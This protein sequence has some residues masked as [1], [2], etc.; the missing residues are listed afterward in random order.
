M[1]G[2][3]AWTKFT[4]ADT[5]KNGFELLRCGPTTLGPFVILSREALA[6][7]LHYW[8]GKSVPH[9]TINCPACHAKRPKRKIGRA[10]CRERV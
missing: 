2:D 1:S 9:L 7:E 8:Q 4:T 5:A 6:V 3:I 10:S